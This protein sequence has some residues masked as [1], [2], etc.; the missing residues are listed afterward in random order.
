L[1]FSGSPPCDIRNIFAEWPFPAFTT[2]VKSQSDTCP[3]GFGFFYSQI[4]GIFVR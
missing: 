2:G 1:T 3:N 4:V